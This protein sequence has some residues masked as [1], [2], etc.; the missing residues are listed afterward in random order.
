MEF[1]E[2]LNKLS[3]NNIK[4]AEN[5]EKVYNKGVEIGKEQSLVYLSNPDMVAIDDYGFSN[6]QYLKTVNCPGLRKIGAAAF[7]GCK[8]LE[9]IVL[10]DNVAYIG[11]NAFKGCDKLKIICLMA[12]KPEGWDEDWNPD[13][14]PVEWGYAPVE[15]W[16]VP[17]T[18]TDNITVKVYSSFENKDMYFFVVGGTGKMYNFSSADPAPWLSYKDLTEY[19]VFND[20]ITEVGSRSF[21]N[22]VNIKN[23]YFPKTLTYV[24]QYAFYNVPLITTLS[25]PG[26][27]AIGDS[28]FQGCRALEKVC[29]DKGFKTITARGF[30]NCSSLKEFIFPSTTT[31][32]GY[33][34]STESV[35]TGCTS[36]EKLIILSKDVSILPN[37]EI[38][39]PEWVTIYCFENSTAHQYALTYNRNYVLIEEGEYTEAETSLYQF[40]YFEEQLGIQAD[41]IEEL[42]AAINALPTLEGA[43]NLFWEEIQN[44]GRR[45][46]YRYGFAYWDSEY[47]RPKYKVVPT[48]FSGSIFYDCNNLKKIEAGYFDFSQLPIGTSSEPSMHYTFAACDNLVEIEDVGLSPSFSYYYTFVWSSKLKK[49]AKMRVDAATRFNNTF[50]NCYALEEVGIEGEIATNGLDFQSCDKLSKETINRVI[51]CLSTS[52]AGLT[53]TF[54]ATSINQAFETDIG[55]NDGSTSSSWLQLVAT[56]TNWTIS[57]V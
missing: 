15:S 23:I 37:S 47:I 4:I 49:I 6:S 34:T 18:E 22:F 50:S 44:H 42:D 40:N 32:I 53:V 52:T 30:K 12:E 48:S 46:N 24:S 2:K 45:T 31:R 25:I 20:G 21:I 5:Q 54:S 43:K 7:E 36:L 56:K 55:A 13:S 8:I 26:N 38:A 16:E 29:L 33:Q 57:L 19:V 27:T 41:L 1:L 9:Q 28:T 51:S 17:Q 35:F 3:E 11:K 10:Y 14:C 39:I